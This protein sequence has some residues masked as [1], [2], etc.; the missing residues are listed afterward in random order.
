MTLVIPSLYLIRHCETKWQ[1]SGRHTG[2]TDLPLTEHGADMACRLRL[3]LAHMPFSLV[4]TSPMH[5][6]RETCRLA[7]LGDIAQVSDDLSE[8]D[9]G[10]YEGRS[11][12]DICKKTPDWNIFRDGCPH[13]ETPS[14][15]TARADR[16]IAK[17]LM[18]KGTIALFTHGQFACAL[19]VRWIGLSV[20]AGQHFALDPGTVSVLGPKPGHPQVRVIAKWNDGLFLSDSA[21]VAKDGDTCG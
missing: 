11:S 5:R 18:L 3:V 21:I 9:Y 13:G 8:W 6:A 17:L 4:L 7:G 16:L 14:Q 1:L 12:H 2:I 19:A 10:D 20:L 15:V